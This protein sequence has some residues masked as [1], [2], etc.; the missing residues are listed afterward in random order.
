M[1]IEMYSNALIQDRF[2]KIYGYSLI[3]A[4]MVFA[5]AVLANENENTSQKNPKGTD[6]PE[7]ATNDNT[8]LIPKTE[9]EGP[10][11]EFDFPSL[12]IGV[13][14]YEEGAYRVHRVLFSWRCKI[15]G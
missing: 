15:C 1:E 3:I 9:F 12:H 11:L 10:V 13:A 2:M 7:P 4:I 8:R 5:S 14:E 6:N